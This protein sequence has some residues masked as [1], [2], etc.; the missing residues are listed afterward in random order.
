METLNAEAIRGL[1]SQRLNVKPPSAHT[2][3]QGTDI[4]A[5]MTAAMHKLRK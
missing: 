3:T 5:K 2:P 4:A 1:P